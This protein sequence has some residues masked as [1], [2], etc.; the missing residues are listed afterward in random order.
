MAHNRLF[1]DFL[2][3]AS[4]GK[5]LG[6]SPLFKFGQNYDIDTGTLP[7][8]IISWGGYK[9][10]P[11]TSSTVSIVSSNAQD[12]VAGTGIQTLSIEGL[13]SEYNIISEE[14][15]LNGV[16]PVVTTNSYY[17]V[18]RMKG[19]LAGSNQRAEGDIT[20]THSEGVISEVVSSTGQ[21]QDCTYTVPANHT[22]LLD[23]MKASIERTNAGAGAEIHF[24]IMNEGTNVWRELASL[25]IIASGTSY[26]IRDTD[27][28][29]PIPEKTDIRIHCSQVATNNTS[30]ACAFEGLLIDNTKF[31]W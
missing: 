28:W 13:D 15:I 4:A 21:S 10:F 27:M 7:E 11:T 19:T 18:Y 24:E 17:R 30:V 26:A 16:T 14:I 22:L 6:V 3:R 20:A 23:R 12:G 5:I 8:D 1:P 29:L 31:A 2:I 25:S 9:L